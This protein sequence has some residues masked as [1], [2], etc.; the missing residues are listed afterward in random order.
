MRLHDVTFDGATV[1][2]SV[3]DEAKGPHR[4]A[5]IGSGGKVLDRQ[6]GRE[7][8]FTMPDGFTGYVRVQVDDRGGHRAWTQPVWRE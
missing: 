8:S 1:K 2:V 3:A 7:A 4:F 5:F 6:R